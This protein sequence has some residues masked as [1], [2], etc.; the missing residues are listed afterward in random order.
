MTRSASAE[1]G[2]FGVE[3]LFTESDI[4]ELIVLD[5]DV[6]DY[7]MVTTGAESL[8]KKDELR[9]EGVA[10]MSSDTEST[11]PSILTCRLHT[12]IGQSGIGDIFNDNIQGRNEWLLCYRCNAKQRKY[13][14]ASS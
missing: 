5:R 7:K 14:T 11:L 2:S 13:N 8:D 4:S 12:R 9:E 10:M 1:I 3:P 6:L